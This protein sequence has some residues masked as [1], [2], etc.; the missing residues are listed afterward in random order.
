MEGEE[1]GEEAE[2]HHAG[3]PRRLAL[4]RAEMD[5]AEPVEERQLHRRY[6]PFPSLLP[7]P[8]PDPDPGPWP[9]F[10]APSAFR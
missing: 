10:A 2:Q 8:D 1:E 6:P 4:A 7:D 9:G 3:D 5:V